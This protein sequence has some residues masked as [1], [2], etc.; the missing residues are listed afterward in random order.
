MKKIKLWWYRKDPIIR[1]Y[2]KVIIISGIL[3]A[4]CEVITLTK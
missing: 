3:L 4:I 2:D 1:E